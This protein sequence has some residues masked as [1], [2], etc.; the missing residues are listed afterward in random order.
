MGWSWLQWNGILWNVT[1]DKGFNFEGL[2]QNGL[3]HK[4]TIWNMMG[5]NES[6]WA[7]KNWMDHNIKVLIWSMTGD[8]EYYF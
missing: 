2:E 6:D 3:Q 1:E 4:N 8:D 7:E 5:V